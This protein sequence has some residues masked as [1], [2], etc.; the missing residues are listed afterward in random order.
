MLMQAVPDLDAEILHRLIS[1]VFIQ[2]MRDA[3]RVAFYTNSETAAEAREWLSGDGL[4]YAAHLNIE[5][6]TI[7][8]ALARMQAARQQTRKPRERKRVNE[9]P[10]L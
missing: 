6:E 5:P 8:P 2:A 10:N 9:L 3:A 1:A 7:D 4:Y